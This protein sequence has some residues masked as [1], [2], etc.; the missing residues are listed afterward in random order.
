MQH[1]A[2]T[3]KGGPA[4]TSEVW[5]CWACKRAID[6]DAR[7]RDSLDQNVKTKA[8]QQEEWTREAQWQLNTKAT[9]KHIMC[10]EC[11]GMTPEVLKECRR[12]DQIAMH[13]IRKATQACI[14]H[15][16]EQHNSANGNRVTATLQGALVAAQRT[17]AQR[18][19]STQQWQNRWAVLAGVL[20]T[21]AEGDEE[22]K[23]GPEKECAAALNESVDAAAHT[24]TK[25]HQCAKA[26]HIATMATAEIG[27]LI[28][29]SMCT[30]A[31]RFR[32]WLSRDAG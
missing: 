18:A 15:K 32:T 31:S 30:A 20:P 16:R 25:W 2:H 4:T 13:A 9:L 12:R 11:K 19:V 27:S 24:V 14:E 17:C 10:G 5:G 21:W 22:D 1:S 7:Q 26:G 29:T 23:K 8:Q 6:L 3:H 28:Y